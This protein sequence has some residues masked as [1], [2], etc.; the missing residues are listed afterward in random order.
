LPDCPPADWLELKVADTGI[1]IKAEDLPRLF[2][3]FVQLDD[4][5]TKRHEG[6]GLGLAFTRKLVELHGGRIGATSEGEGR[7]STFTVI[8]PLAGSG[9]TRSV[10]PDAQFASRE[11]GDL[12]GLRG[13]SKCG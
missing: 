13:D 10:K 9:A 8:L 5:V 11:P 12:D 7:G 1:G 6:V 3:E 4:P 2:R